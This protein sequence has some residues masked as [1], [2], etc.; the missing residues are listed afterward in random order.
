MQEILHAS[1]QYRELDQYIA[2]N[3]IKKICIVHGDS[4]RHL[5]INSYIEELARKAKV[6][7][8]SDFISNPSYESVVKGVQVFR[9]EKCDAILAI[10]GGSAMDVAKCIKLYST[11][12]GN[13][14]NG[15]FLK[16]KPS[17]NNIK[18]LAVPTTSGTGSEATRYAVIY[19]NGKKQSI[20]DK[21][22]IPD[23][24]LFDDSVLDTLS[25]YQRKS[26]MM[27]ALCHA[28]E[29]HWS[30]NSTDES[31]EYS[32]QAIRLILDNMEDYLAGNKATFMSMLIAA[33]MAGKAINIAQTTAGHAMCYM[34]SSKYGIAHGHA[35][36]LCVRKLW[37]MMLNVACNQCCDSRGKEYLLDIFKEI[38]KLM[39][40]DSSY[41]A[42]WKFNEIF[43]N[44]GLG[45]PDAT[46]DEIKEFAKGV[47]L[48]R[49]R[50]TP[51]ELRKNDFILLYGDILD[52]SRAVID[53]I[54]ISLARNLTDFFCEKSIHGKIYSTINGRTMNGDNTDNMM[55]L[56][57]WKKQL[58]KILIP[59]DRLL[60]TD[61]FNI[62]G[63]GHIKMEITL[64]R[65]GREE[66][67]TTGF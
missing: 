7:S 35:V 14:D 20:T 1:D 65:D 55:Q 33:N 59:G 41:Q 27:D 47:N 42:A 45:V 11:S 30:V 16:T 50:N 13:G 58:R 26:T 9:R 12:E 54:E 31:K 44:L 3:G 61:N 17:D 38:A 46:F 28:I 24:V 40:C 2:R 56:Q 53:G 22:I 18:L 57:V 32:R 23:A 37:P 49:L 60:H 4:L 34:L 62:D 36:A 19:Y 39:G 48:N 6:I 51:V 8:F 63:D 66:T 5:R 15:S 10:G 67:F 52:S 64:E 21:S 43:L 25:E 29:A